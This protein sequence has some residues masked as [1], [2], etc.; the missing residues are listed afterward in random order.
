M[1]AG[2]KA[3][4]KH[5]QPAAADTMPQIQL[6][7]TTMPHQQQQQKEQTKRWRRQHKKNE[8]KT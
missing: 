7:R 8:M 4:G 3:W 6:T 5:Y 1:T 2:G